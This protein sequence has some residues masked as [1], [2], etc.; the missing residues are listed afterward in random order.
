MVPGLIS[1]LMTETDEWL[2]RRIQAVYWKQWKRVRTRY[3]IF[4]ASHLKEWRVHELENCRKGTWR[5][6]Q[7]LS[8]VLTNKILEKL[9]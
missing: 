6:A 5:A 2:R 8:P 4:M 7:M 3:C 9:G 1:A